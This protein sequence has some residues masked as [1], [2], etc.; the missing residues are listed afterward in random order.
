MLHR[1]ADLR[2]A[3]ACCV[4]LLA[5]CSAPPSIFSALPDN[6]FGLK[7]AAPQPAAPNE[8][9]TPEDCAAELRRLVKDPKRDW[10]G[11]PQS[12]EGYATG[13]RLFA[14]RG[15][16]KKLSCNEIKRALEEMETAGPSLKE[17]KYA[18]TEALMRNVAHELKSERG[19]RCR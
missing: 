17:R 3:A 11:R 7:P 6:L 16:R 9:S 15:L 1:L 13:T 10:I 12:T 19:K 2:A 18:R 14:Y 5:G 4:L 8:C